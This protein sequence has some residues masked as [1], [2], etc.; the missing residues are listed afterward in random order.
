MIKTEDLSNHVGSPILPTHIRQVGSE[1][2]PI[3]FDYQAVSGYFVHQTAYKRMPGTLLTVRRS[4]DVLIYGIVE[5]PSH[6]QNRACLSAGR[7]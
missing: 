1:D 7:R 3:V 5:Q 2:G 4:I 6:R